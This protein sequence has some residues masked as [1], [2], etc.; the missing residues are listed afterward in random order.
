MPLRLRRFWRAHPALSIAIG[1][2]AGVLIVLIPTLFT[3]F[4]DWGTKWKVIPKLV[5]LGIWGVSVILVVSA[6]TVQSE[7]LR[8]LFAVERKRRNRLREVAARYILSRIL[9]PQLAGFP[10]HYELRLYL[11]DPTGK[12]LIS[13]YPT[14]LGTDAWDVGRGI[15]GRSFQR[16]SYI[17]ARG[18]AVSDATYDLTPEQQAKYAE[19]RVVASAPIL[20]ARVR[21]IGVL[22]ASTKEDDEFLAKPEGRQLHEEL[23]EVVARVLIDLVG[24]EAD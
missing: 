20:D 9:V 23:A 22:T 16:G 13:E 12:T 6:S 11:P 14:D 10:R 17:V 5:A 19:L 15:T 2:V 8:E 21:P 4:P 7:R 3:L 1:L 18:A 24:I